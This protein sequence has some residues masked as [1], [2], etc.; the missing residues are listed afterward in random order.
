MAITKIAGELLESNLIRVQDLS[1]SGGNPALQHLLHVDVTNGRIGVKTD[2]PGNFALD[3]NGN[4]R[5]Q[6][7]HTITGDL[8][9]EGTTTTIDS[10][11]LVVEDNII[12]LN[13]N[14]SSATDAGLMINRTGENNAVFYWDEVRNKFRVG[15]TTSD[16]ST[17]TDLSSV[18]LAR[19]QVATPTAD[20]DAAHKKYI[21]DSVAALSTSGSSING[22]TQELSTP[23]DS[24]FGDGSFTGLTSTTKVTDAI[25]SL[26]ETMENIRNGTYV[27]KVT[28]SASPTSGSLGTSVALNILAVGGG[29]N[30][31]DINWGD[32]SAIETV[33]STTPS[34]TYNENSGQPYTI[35][36]KAYNNTAV[37]DSAGSFANSGDSQTNQTITIFTAQPVPA[38]QMFAAP[39]GGS[40]I[41][42]V[43][44]GSTV[45][46]QNNT[47]NTAGATVT[48]DVDWGDNSEQSI[49]GDSGVAGGSSANGGTRLAH[50]YTN[51]A[52]DDGST[53]AG[54]GAGDTKYQI[55]L[56]LLT[57]STADPSIIP[58]QTTSN[59][60]VYSTHTPL[61]SVADSTIR[62]VNEEATSGFPVTFTNNTATLPG[63][64]SQFSATQQYT[65]NFGEGDSP[66]TTPIGAGGTG[67][68]GQTINNTFNLSS[69]NQ[70][71]GVTSTFTTSLNLS[72]GHSSSPFS[73]NINIIVE[74]DV[75]ANIAATANIVST[76]SGD[77]QYDLYDVV[78][79]DGANRALTTFTNTSQ[80]ADDYDYDFFTDSSDLV[81]VVENGSNAGSIGATLS[82]NFSGT[83][84]GNFTTTFRA[85]GTP[86]TIEQDDIETIAWQ[87]NSAPTA[88]ANLSTKSLTLS[89]SAQGTSPK[90]CAGFDDASS[91]FTSQ[92]AG[93]SLN[94]PTARRYTSG[95]IDT[96]TASNFLTN[97]SNGTG[98][99]VNQ[100]VT[101]KIN[102]A[103]R[104]N[105]TFTTSEGGA[106]NATFTS[107]VTT[108]HRDADEVSTLP[109]RMFLVATAKITQ[110][111][112]DYST[113]SNAQRLESSA[114]GNTNLVY[115]VR[116]LLTGTPTT[117]IG[118]VA[119][120][121][122]GTK[123]HVSGIPYYDAGSPTVTVTGTT[124]ANFT[125]QAFQDTNS[126][127]QIHNDTNQ[128][129]TSGD[130]I[131]DSAYTYAQIDGAST[132]LTGSVPNKNT[133][134][135]SPYTL[136]A[137]TAPITSSSVKTVKTI[138]ARSKNANG[139]GSY[140]SSSTKIQVYKT[141]A[142]S[143]LDNEAGG[144]T[145]SDSLGDGSTHTDDAK[146]IT[147]FGSSSDTPSFNSATNYYTSNA[148][149]GAVTVAGTTEAISRFGTIKHFTTDLSSGYLPVGPDL[150]TGRD[151]GQ[152]QYYT[153]A[154]RRTNVANFNLTMS[155]KVSGMFIAAPG[156]AIDS[157]SSLNGWLDCST[158][159]GGSGVP[160][161]N[162]GAGGNG[163][164]GC[165]F[166]S[167][168][169]VVDGTTYSSQEFTFTLGTENAS[170]A[171]GNNI[172][173]R[174][175]LES[176]DSITALSID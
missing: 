81:T 176:G 71:N 126:P 133:G 5:T 64:N 118:T 173:V 157:A 153:F 148:W 113:G 69:S 146:R 116:D 152:A 97:N 43:D 56:R 138:R 150:N 50:T 32:G 73:S 33:T 109:Q 10:Q 132:M 95:T 31:F 28:Y 77:N 139:T 130:A 170:N 3:V 114:G 51:S 103:D 47:T 75:R 87:M 88:P 60:E 135:G 161:A 4:T 121:T 115:V 171:T 98:S 76:K 45:Y 174:I 93:D 134:V 53:V 131:T 145:V 52:G 136:A 172:L 39:S 104:G 162:S 68:T 49:S 70:N 124:V 144:I 159:Y 105:R 151:G 84:A 57:H 101:A 166:N 38:F 141:A 143:G 79:L 17:R 168:D 48:Y 72:N 58:A 24:T 120:G 23:T 25:D 119:E 80:N 6:G 29:A 63:A 66:V 44:N 137:L 82:K 128:E 46:L 127:H 15:T 13:E 163:S 123:L 142:L 83:S 27:K 85:H 14:A 167:G 94:T 11:N 154:F 41:T 110:A 16:G 22:M 108:N 74:P 90:L 67:D 20:D 111:L 169:R 12:T 78:D 155:G 26:N 54:T 91:S 156:T 7:S 62:G 8:V 96:N 164:N 129:S 61:Y 99:T 40:P 2:S 125:G 92:T 89:D 102:N 175:K 30:R 122:A 107:L 65:Y 100:T 19:L 59:F 106:N 147:G 42:K 160:G 140:N 37:T 1:F 55:R 158:T 18:N 117:T 112:T 21:D 86:D 35:S 34:H 165:A 9:V 36:V 149:S